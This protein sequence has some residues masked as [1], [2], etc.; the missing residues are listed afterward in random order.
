LETLNKH[1]TRGLVAVP[2]LRD[3]FVIKMDI[4]DFSVSGLRLKDCID[5]LTMLSVCKAL[6]C[7]FDA[8]LDAVVKTSPKEPALKKLNALESLFRDPQRV[9][10]KVNLENPLI[11]DSKLISNALEG[12]RKYRRQLVSY[13]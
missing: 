12:V 10:G 13:I 11:P 1:K 8:L 3:A 6:N 5:I 7:D 2:S 4:M 9:V